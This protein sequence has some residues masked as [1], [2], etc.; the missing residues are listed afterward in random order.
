M[1]LAVGIVG[2]PNVGKSTLFNALSNAGAQSANYPFCTI[3]PNVGMVSVP[4]PRI[5]AL[6]KVVEPDKIVPTTVEFVDIAGLVKGASQGEGLGNQFLA[7][8]RSVDAIVH[9]VRCFEDENIIHVGGKVDPLAD[10]EVI[11]TE[12]ILR[13]MQSVDQRL[14]KAKKNAKGGDKVERQALVTC[15]K[16]MALLDKGQTVRTMELDDAD[17][18][19]LEPLALLTQKP[20]LYA[21]NVAEHQ[22]A[23]GL[24]DPLVARLVEHA[25][26]EGS[27]VVVISAAIEAE[28]AG[29]SPEERAE[30]LASIGAD[31]PGLSR[32]IRKAYEL[33]ELITYF[34]AGKQEVRAW[35]IRRG[36]L[37]PGAAGKIHSDFER[38]FIRAEV[39]RWT[40]LVELGSEAAVKSKGLLRVE[41]K[42]Y[43]VQDGDV[44]HF[45][46]NV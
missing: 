13:D 17:R 28:I 46:F 36:T 23:A 30:F 2:L 27:E 31:E 37:A 26:R 29:L 44:M 6:V 4:D 5:D 39:M 10:V 34:T 15:E 19:I 43:V 21:A 41:G 22:L 42:E 32:L 9:V 18:E 11:N 16:V 7:H 3:E 35:T 38:G 12:L 45:R 40:D 20:V 33:L 14:A 24:Q 8:I 1:A 25:A